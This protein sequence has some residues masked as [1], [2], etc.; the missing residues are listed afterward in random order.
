MSWLKWWSKDEVKGDKSEFKETDIN[1]EILMFQLDYEL[2]DTIDIIFKP[3]SKNNFLDTGEDSDVLTITLD[4][5]NSEKFTNIIDEN[6]V[7]KLKLVVGYMD[8]I[9]MSNDSTHIYK[10]NFFS[11]QKESIEIEYSRKDSSGSNYLTFEEG[12]TK[13]EIIKLNCVFGSLNGDGTKL[14]I[15]PAVFNKNMKQSRVE[16]LHSSLTIGEIRFT[17]TLIDSLPT[18]YG[19][20]KVNVNLIFQGE[21]PSSFYTSQLPLNDKYLFLWWNKLSVRTEDDCE[22]DDQKRN[23]FASINGAYSDLLHL[24]LIEKGKEEETPISTNITLECLADNSTLY[25]RMYV[26]YNKVFF[27]NEVKLPKRFE[28]N[29]EIEGCEIYEN[30]FTYFDG[31]TEQPSEITYIEKDYGLLL[32]MD[33]PILEVDSQNTKQL[34]LTFEKFEQIGETEYLL[35]KY[36]NDSNVIIDI[37]LIDTEDGIRIDENVDYENNFNFHIFLKELVYVTG[38]CNIG[39]LDTD[40]MNLYI[41]HNIKGF[42]EKKSISELQT[43]ICTINEVYA[44]YNQPIPLVNNQIIPLESSEVFENTQDGGKLLK[45][46]DSTNT[47]CMVDKCYCTNLAPKDENQKRFGEIDVNLVVSGNI[48]DWIYSWE[49]YSGTETTYGQLPLPYNLTNAYQENYKL[50]TSNTFHKWLLVSIN[51]LPQFGKD[52]YLGIADDTSKMVEN[53]SSIDLTGI[54]ELDLSEN[55]WKNFYV[56]RVILNEPSD[57]LPFKGYINRTLFDSSVVY[58][59]P[60]EPIGDVND[61]IEGFSVIINEGEEIIEK[62]VTK[63]YIKPQYR[64]HFLD[65]EEDRYSTT[66]TINLN[67]ENTDKLTNV[68]D[69]VESDK[70]VTD[71]TV[72]ELEII[73]SEMELIENEDNKDIIDITFTSV[74]KAKILIYGEKSGEKQLFMEYKCENII[75]RIMNLNIIHGETESVNE[76]KYLVPL[77][78]ENIISEDTQITGIPDKALKTYNSIST[79]NPKMITEHFKIANWYCANISGLYLTDSTVQFNLVVNGDIPPSVYLNWLPLSNKYIGPGIDG[80]HQIRTKHQISASSI[81]IRFSSV[82]AIPSMHLGIAMGTISGSH[83]DESELDLSGTDLN[84]Q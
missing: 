36:L 59:N 26:D 54:N 11:E 47:K 2:N 27:V 60:N 41:Y 51:A 65:T 57:T 38:N 61:I 48:P 39:L 37:T 35:S 79:L 45:F 67:K 82:N 6:N 18:A 5:T 15:Y 74:D 55:K 46:E 12:V 19:L 73:V 21:L 23:K 16:T 44:V 63:M 34:N 83:Y 9:S 7:D 76:M 29:L 1:S 14:E 40:S 22:D 33:S 70:E 20:K 43:K 78:A 25:E 42:R 13:F 69:E 49:S 58:P 72:Y 52:K 32:K 62:I 17:N 80:K 24:P 28:E 8:I 64:N 4:S 81:E 84:E 75:Y 56:N 66:L 71:E 68:I 3:Q 50:L 31:N 77:K 10:A 53:T 30:T